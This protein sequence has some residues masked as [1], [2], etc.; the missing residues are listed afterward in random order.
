ML[1][2]INF[3]QERFQKKIVPFSAQLSAL[4]IVLL[5]ALL[6]V[7]SLWQSWNISQLV[8]EAEK[9]EKQHGIVSSQVADL[10]TKI[11][12]LSDEAGLDEK[13]Q[14]KT[15]KIQ[16][17][18]KALEFVNRGQLVANEGFA[19]RLESLSRLSTKDVWLSK[20]ELSFDYMLL[21]GSSLKEESVP[22]YFQKFEGESLF[23]GMS[24]DVFEISRAEDS[25][26]KVDF[27]IASHSLSDEGGE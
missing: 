20:I 18:K 19:S 11:K 21:Q 1:Q 14:A 23:K 8:A 16:A 4:S 10:E 15:A 26:W 6:I 5:L 25:P 22:L 7:V 12:R 27:V 9:Q 17:A 3:Y 2:Q 24:F 13:I